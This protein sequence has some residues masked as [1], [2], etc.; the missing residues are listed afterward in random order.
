MSSAQQGVRSAG[1]VLTLS[2]PGFE[3]AAGSHAAASILPRHEHALPTICCVA[4]GRFQEYYAGRSVDCDART[5]KV[6]PAGDPHW[7]RFERVETRGI[8]IDVDPARFEEV[9]PIRR[10]LGER[11]FFQSAGFSGWTRRLLDELA[12]PDEA[13]G[14]ATESLLLEL[15]ARLSRMSTASAGTQPGWLRQADEIVHDSFRTPLTLAGVAARVDVHPATLARAYRRAHGRTVGERIRELR[16]ELAAQ[17]LATTTRSLSEIALR[18]GFYDQSHFCNVFR[19][20][21]QLTPARYRA[22]HGGR[23]AAGAPVADGSDGRC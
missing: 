21:R 20:Q 19:R 17:E 12:A 18:A 16:I 8:R 6:T 13:A 2:V 5:V 14:V 15:L 22:R 1:G 23:A 3:L 4:R 7:N 11:S 9:G 10:L